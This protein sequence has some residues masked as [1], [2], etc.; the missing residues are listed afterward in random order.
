MLSA[1]VAGAC[2]LC[3]SVISFDM[4]YLVHAGG[5]KAEQ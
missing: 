5:G 2:A 3:V 1:G 4:L